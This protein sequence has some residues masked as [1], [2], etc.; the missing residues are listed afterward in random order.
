MTSAAAPIPGPSTVRAVSGLVTRGFLEEMGRQWRTHG[1]LFE[2]RLGPRRLLVAVH[3][4]AV[5]EVTMSNRRDFDKLGSYD[6]VRDY[7]TG[8]GLIASTGDLW[9][10]QRRLMAPMFTPRGVQVYGETMLT[11]ALRLADRW[12]E[13]AVSGTRVD[14]GE[15]MTELTASIIVSALFSSDSTIAGL[16]Q[17]VSTMIGYANARAGGMAAPT[18]APTPGARRYVAARK[19][20][21]GFIESLIRQRRS[22]PEAEWPDDLLTRLMQARDDETGASMA[23]DLLRDESI[24]MFFAGHETTARTMTATWYALATNPHVAVRLHEELDAVQGDPAGVASG[25][26]P[27]LDDLKRLPYTLQVVK[28]VLRLYPAA[29][30]YV[31]DAVRDTT[32]MGREVPAGASVMLSP[33]YTHR[34]PEFWFDAE[35]FDPDRWKPAREKAQ[36]P[37]AFHP[38]ASGER[39]CIGN[40]FS[41]LESH[42][43]LA[44][45]AHRYAPQLPAG[46][47][48]KWKMDGV[49]TSANGM[50]MTI[51]RR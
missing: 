33:Y 23:D 5:R 49:L 38:F 41:L 21:H 12:G 25:T 15:E 11:D 9:K 7:L 20:V 32:V 24:T 2:M 46:F 6:T 13:L 44:V 40:H 8:Q 1:D 16:H 50:P 10:R 3:P 51:T 17:H 45:L 35:R 29:P 22:M 43:L 48:P 34:H 19:A 26:P 42:I 14:M 47:T 27:T 39:V 31:R 37:T 36:H 30:F 28:E 4:E 18:W